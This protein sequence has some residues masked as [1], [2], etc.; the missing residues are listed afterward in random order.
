M[1][2]TQQIL[3][4]EEAII[5]FN[6][7]LSNFATF[8]LF[9]IAG[10]VF[11][12]LLSMV[13]NVTFQFNIVFPI[14]YLLT[15]TF[16]LW[17]SFKLL[18]PL[19][20]YQFIGTGIFVFYLSVKVTNIY[21]GGFLILG[22]LYMMI[23]VLPKI[24]NLTSQLLWLNFGALSFAY[25]YIIINSQYYD[26]YRWYSVLFT[27]IL[28]GIPF[29]FTECIQT[30]DSIIGKLKKVLLNKAK[31]RMLILLFIAVSTLFSVYQLVYV[32]EGN[33]RYFSQI[34][35][36]KKFL[37]EI[38]NN[39]RPTEDWIRQNVGNRGREKRLFYIIKSMF[40]MDEL[41]QWDI[42]STVVF[43]PL[44]I[45]NEALHMRI[46]LKPTRPIIWCKIYPDNKIGV[47]FY[48]DLSDRID[49]FDANRDGEWDERDIERIRFFKKTKYV[50]EKYQRVLGETLSPGK[51]K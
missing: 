24:L 6:E 22:I 32:L 29:L 43:G 8:V 40:L 42:L 37:I 18:G 7:K 10:V 34:E 46:K 26:R 25:L 19:R 36:V 50:T 16:F 17:Y 41:T 20:L 4:K 15:E 2:E 48:D 12:M 5:S 44:P 21:F 23:N 14:L 47:I 38:I 3:K 31:F 51:P 13:V 28:M 39:E 45:S 9:N 35:K 30:P 11:L 27:F 49:Q 1:T 33:V